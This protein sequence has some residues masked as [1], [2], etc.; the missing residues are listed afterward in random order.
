MNLQTPTAEEIYSAAAAAGARPDPL[1]TISQWA[2][3]YRM[4]SQRASAESGPWRTERTPYLREIMDCLSPSSPIERVVFMKGAQ[5][6]GPLALD[7]PLP[8]LFGWTTMGQV[9]VGDRL[10]DENGQPC[11]V[12]SVSPI[13]TG[14]PCFRLRL[15]DGAEFICDAEHRWI[16]WDDLGAGKRSLIKATTSE[17]FP[18]HKVRGVRNR[19]AIDVAGPLSTPRPIC[20]WIPICSA[21]GWATARQR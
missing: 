4:L 1:L 6:G 17:M 21:F 19:F 11:V 3:K 7:T 20:R 10:F 14:R 13:F 16:V 12:R 8:T 15:S 5:I 9:Q 18:R 2:D